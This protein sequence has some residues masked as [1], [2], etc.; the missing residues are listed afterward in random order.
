MVAFIDNEM[1]IITDDIIDLSFRVGSA[2]M[3]FDQ[4][5]IDGLEC[6]IW[7][8]RTFDFWL[9]T[10]STLPFIRVGRC[11]AAASVVQ[12]SRRTG[13][14]SERP[15]KSRRNRAIFLSIDEFRSMGSSAFAEGTTLI[16]AVLPLRV[17]RRASISATISAHSCSNAVSRATSSAILASICVIVKVGLRQRYPSS[18]ALRK[19]AS[20]IVAQKLSISPRPKPVPMSYG[21]YCYSS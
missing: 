9:F 8:C 10:N 3:A 6:L 16:A 15:W 14:T 11:V 19:F 12:F 21:I 4:H 1:T 7:T 20:P 18:S 17:D 5:V 13:K 2:E